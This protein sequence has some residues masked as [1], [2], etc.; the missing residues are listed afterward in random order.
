MLACLSHLPLRHPLPAFESS[1]DDR[2]CA[3]G[4]EV[5][6]ITRLRKSQGNLGQGG[7]RRCW[8]HCPPQGEAWHE[9]EVPS[10]PWTRLL[11]TQCTWRHQL[12]PWWRPCSSQGR[13]N[14]EEGVRVTDLKLGSRH[15]CNES[16]KTGSDNSC[17]GT[18]CFL[19]THGKVGDCFGNVMYKCLLRLKEQVQD[20]VHADVNNGFISAYSLVSLIGFKIKVS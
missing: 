7:R 15:K 14:G 12:L 16:D 8:E 2:H 20:K 3:E 17:H 5:S 6:E 9:S 4:A 10:A 19:F 13:E 11:T 18:T 1:G